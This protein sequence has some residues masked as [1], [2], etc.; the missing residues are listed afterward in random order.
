[1][2][3]IF[4]VVGIIIP[5]FFILYGLADILFPKWHV[6]GELAKG[7][8]KKDD[9]KVFKRATELSKKYQQS[10][11]RIRLMGILYLI[12]AASALITRLLDI[13]DLYNNIS[14]SVLI[15]LFGIERL[16]V[17]A[18]TFDNKGDELKQKQAKNKKSAIRWLII[19]VIL[20]SMSFI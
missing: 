18:F 9:D 4:N 3:T 7:M 19:G 12:V 16:L 11:N 8:D 2:E 14:T 5:I 17:P 15:M 6:I 20:L 10:M 13:P 1:M